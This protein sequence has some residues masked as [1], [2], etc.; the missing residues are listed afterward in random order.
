MST[1][2]T[3]IV[4]TQPQTFDLTTFAVATTTIV[5]NLATM[6]I[7]HGFLATISSF[8]PIQ[9]KLAKPTLQVTGK[10]ASGLNFNAI[11][12]GTLADGLAIKNAEVTF[13]FRGINTIDGKSY[14]KLSV[15]F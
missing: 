8:R 4:A 9:T 14:P 13:V 12:D 2:N 5:E 3:P 7:G 1:V 15:Q 11:V 6:Q 10:T